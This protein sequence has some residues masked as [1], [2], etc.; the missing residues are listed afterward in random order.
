MGEARSKPVCRIRFLIDMFMGDAGDIVNVW[1]EDETALYYY[2]SERRWCY[3]NKSDE[4]VDWEY[5]T[6]S[7]KTK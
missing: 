5:V 4:D 2:D 3:V 7:R 6:R 1:A